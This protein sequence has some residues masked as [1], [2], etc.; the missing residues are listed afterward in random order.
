MN[1]TECE[2][3]GEEVGPSEAVEHVESVETVVVRSAS[4]GCSVWQPR[5]R[6][7]KELIAECEYPQ[8]L[9]LKGSPLDADVRTSRGLGYREVYFS[10][11]HIQAIQLPLHPLIHYFLFGTN[12]CPMQLHPLC[13]F[14]K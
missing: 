7:I 8:F 11:Y 3:T 14:H 4:D 1:S 6:Q 12:L 5:A 13:S 10:S 9:V 2:P